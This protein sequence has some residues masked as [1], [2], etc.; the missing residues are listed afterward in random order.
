MPSEVIYWIWA[1][2]LVLCVAAA[3]FA[4]LFSLPGNW[5]MVVLIV[6]FAVFYPQ[7]DGRGVGWFA[8]AVIAG[9]AVVGELIEFAAGAAGAAKEGGSRRG[10]LLAILGTVVGSIA[11]AFVG[12]PIPIVGPIIAAVGGGVLGEFC[13]AYLGETW[14]GKTSAESIAVGKAALIG[15]LLGT[16]GKLIV[17]AM[18]VVVIALAVIVGWL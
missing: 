1:A 15:R 3:W 17:G 4:T 14:K 6:V 11:G 8:V 12:V 5:V 16:M 13:G 18:M 10:M 2:L 9:L 7:I